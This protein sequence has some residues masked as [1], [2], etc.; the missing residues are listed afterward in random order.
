MASALARGTVS[1]LPRLATPTLPGRCD[2]LVQL[3]G[4]ALQHGRGPWYRLRPRHALAGRATTPDSRIARRGNE[5]P[6]PRR[7]SERP[8]TVL[9]AIRLDGRVAIVTGASSGPGVA[10][11]LALAEAGADIALGA[12][13]V[14][15]L[16]ETKR[17]VEDA[18]RRAIA[19]ATDVA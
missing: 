3:A 12:R 17:L 16:K 11:A 2:G 14:D 19:V 1:G 18:G 6:S 7:T 15:R 4:M 13:R 8:T 5:L 9:D 10:F